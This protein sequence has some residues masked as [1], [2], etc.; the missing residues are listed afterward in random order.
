[1]FYFTIQKDLSNIFSE[2]NTKY[3]INLK[4]HLSYSDFEA[5]DYQSSV[6]FQITKHPQKEQIIQDLI[7]SLNLTGHYHKIEATGKGFLSLKI[8]YDTCLEIDGAVK[9]EVVLVDYCGVNVAKKMHIGHIR[10]MFIGDYIS[11]HYQHLGN[12]VVRINHLGDWGNQFG[13]LLNYIEQN[14]IDIT[15][16]SQLTDCYKKAY[17]LYCSDENFAKL[18]NDIAKLLQNNTEPYLSL[19]KHCCN[20]SIEEMN[21]ITHDFGLNITSND[22]TG[23][24]FYAP[25][26]PFI[27]ELLV[28]SGVVSIGDDGSI[29]YKTKKNYPLMLKK[30]NGAYLYAMYDIAAIYYRISTY[31]PDKII[32]VVDKRQADHFKAV[33][34]ICQEMKWSEHCEF[35][36][37]GFGFIV[38]DNG[39][40]LKT[41]SGDNLY[42]DELLDIGY[43]ELSKQEFYSKLPSG[44]KELVI[45]NTLYGSLKW[46]DLRSNPISDYQFKWENILMN[47]AG[48][49]P[50]I[51][52]AYA[53]IDSL[54][55]KNKQNHTVEID[56]GFI[57][58]TLPNEA[59]DLYKKSQILNEQLFLLC[60]EHACHTL[61]EKLLNVVKA[62]HFFYEKIN[63]SS[64]TQKNELISLLNF[65]QMSIEDSC[66][67][68]GLKPY[69]SQVVW[70]NEY[71]KKLKI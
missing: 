53:R 31:D 35:K 71:Q 6:L 21:N 68:L 26:L 62:F 8:N 57:V 10:S 30:S 70:E 44:Y 47:C 19:W 9:E 40:P 49:A 17:Q 52:H 63:I 7:H 67:I 56:N 69:P 37:L 16:N 18:S 36:H 55:F 41:K 48:T 12:T 46:Y 2:I 27:E 22:I 60:D 29:V 14:N 43:Q 51:F 50:Y 39:I 20:I 42:L 65:V 66:E 38:D 4:P 34:E 33:F 64:S 45:K 58:E 1:M 24:S 59:I 5:Y 28:K 13:Y 11:N 32:Y 15:S 23:E 25:H 3:Q 54:L 61:E